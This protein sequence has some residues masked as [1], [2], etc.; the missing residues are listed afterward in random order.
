MAKSSNILNLGGIPGSANLPASQL[1]SIQNF[2][3]D[4]KGMLLTGLFLG[5]AVLLAFQ[6]YHMRQ[7]IEINKYELD[8]HKADTGK[9]GNG[10]SSM[11]TYQQ[12]TG[13]TIPALFS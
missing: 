7:E 11:P 12:F 8:K 13:G 6:I 1:N 2:M 3:G 5:G 10:N 9:N 4:W